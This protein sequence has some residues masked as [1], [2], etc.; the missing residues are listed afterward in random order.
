MRIESSRILTDTQG[1]I[2]ECFDAIS[3]Q[4]KAF[5]G[6]LQC[7]HFLAK[8]EIAHTTN[9][10]PLVNLAKSL[11]ASYLRE[12]AMGKNTS[13]HFMQEIV[14]ALAETVL[15]PI[16]EDLQASPVFPF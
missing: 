15:E 10:T 1:G 7:M 12:I 3:V 13:E 11:G 4:K 9:F 16:K 2:T 5:I 8:Q 14:L 6:H